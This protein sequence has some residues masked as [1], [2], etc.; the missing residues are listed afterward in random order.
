MAADKQDAHELIERLAPS[1]VPTA[2]GM[3]ERLLDPVARASANAPIDDEP[4]TATTRRLSPKLANGRSI[5][6][7]LPM[8]SSW[9]N[10]ASLKKRSKTIGNRSE[11][12][13]L[14][15]SGQKRC[16]QPGK[17]VAMQLFSALHRF[18]E[19]GVGDVK[20]RQG[21]EELR[22]RIGDYRLLFCLP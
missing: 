9:P 22:L 13:C 1:Q 15:R 14:E 5:T 19:S 7:A 8:K 16:P 18:V 12:D 4:V 3:L 11:A 10:W 6:K 17:P 21:R 20:A 2:V